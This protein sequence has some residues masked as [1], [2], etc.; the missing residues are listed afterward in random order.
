MP[1]FRLELEIGDLRPGHG[2]EEVMALARSALSEH[3]IDA[4]DVAVTSGTPRILLRFTVP[5]GSTAEEDATARL[6]AVRARDS[7]ELVAAT[8]GLWILRRRGGRWLP[9]R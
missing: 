5:D 6:A 1:S 7:V 3:H 4:T 9:L 2:P 8:G